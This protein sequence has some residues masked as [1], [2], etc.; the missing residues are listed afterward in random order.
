MAL[1][2]ST[3]WLAPPKPSSHPESIF[4]ADHHREANIIKVPKL[5]LSQTVQSNRYLL[6]F[7]HELRGFNELVFA[8]KNLS[9]YFYYA[10]HMQHVF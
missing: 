9:M 7:M 3:Q 5:I 10:I 2:S 4:I 8:T 1:E 6:V